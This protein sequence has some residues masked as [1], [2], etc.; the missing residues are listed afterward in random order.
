MELM[1]QSLYINF[2]KISTLLMD[3]TIEIV[4]FD[5]IADV[6]RSNSIK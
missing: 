5:P 3:N 1:K 6:F 2:Q 4:R